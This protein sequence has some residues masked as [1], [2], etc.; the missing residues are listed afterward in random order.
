MKQFSFLKSVLQFEPSP[1]SKVVSVYL[2][3]EANENGKKVHDVFL[4]KQIAEHGAVMQEDSPER[5][6]FDAA[7]E[8]INSFVD[9]IDASTRGVAVFAAAGS[10]ELFEAFEFAVPFESDVFEIADRPYIRPIVQLVEQD[11]PFAV[12]AADSN[13]AHIYV[14]KRGHTIDRQKISN[15]TLS[16]TEAGG[17]SQMRYQRRI[18]GFHQ[19]HA[20][21]VVAEVEKLVRDEGI[22]RVVLCGDEAVIIPMLR[23]ELS[24]EL[25]E[26]VVGT[27]SHNIDTPENELAQAA[28]ELLRSHDAEEDKAMIAQLVE[29]DYDRGRG[30]TGVETTLTALLNGQVQELYMSASPEAV[31]YNRNEVRQVI[32]E[33]QP[34]ED[35]ELP[36]PREARM[37]I[38]ELLRRAAQTADRIRFIEDPELLAAAG[39]VGA[40][41]RYQAKGVTNL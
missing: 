25:S 6:S 40:L 23:S 9:K 22:D 35:S 3:T 21:E 19:A 12:V 14:F 31:R 36:D 2:N 20:K 5:A 41:L 11:P 39:G 1:G 26:K 28:A 29:Q 33:Y 27:L 7:V 32:A 30:V 8:K 15:E 16:R 17:W 34:G 37:V 13:K 38:D 18:D 4:R 10:D 24:K